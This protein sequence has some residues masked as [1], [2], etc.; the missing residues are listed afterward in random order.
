MYYLHYHAIILQVLFLL[1]CWSHDLAHLSSSL[2]VSS[3][4]SWT[5]ARP[6]L[7][8]DPLGRATNSELDLSDRERLFREHVNEIFDVRLA[9]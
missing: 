4:A 6:K 3:Q 8:K 2:L 1:F 9:H 5:E 7:E